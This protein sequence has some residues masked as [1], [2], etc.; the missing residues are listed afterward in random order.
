MVKYIENK[1]YLFPE[2]GRYKNRRCMRGLR[3][4][5]HADVTAFLKPC[6]RQLALDRFSTLIDML[7]AAHF[8]N[9]LPGSHPRVPGTPP[10]PL[11]FLFSH[12]YH[13]VNVRWEP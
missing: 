1:P 8:F 2:P 12:I 13:M 4:V 5:A 9:A 11:Y 6:I 7:L 10:A 3:E